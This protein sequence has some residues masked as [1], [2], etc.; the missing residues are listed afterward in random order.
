MAKHLEKDRFDHALEYI[1]ILIK[2]ADGAINEQKV[3]E[4]RG[5]ELFDAVS[6]L[7]TTLVQIATSLRPFLPATA[8][9]ILR[10]FSSEKIVKGTPLFP[11]LP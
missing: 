1:W 6:D 4:L 9:E 2:Q 3:W 8:E 10:R 11:R 5:R 7:I